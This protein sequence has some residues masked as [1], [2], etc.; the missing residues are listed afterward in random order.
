MVVAYR[1][2]DIIVPFHLGLRDVIQRRRQTDDSAEVVPIVPEPSF[3]DS[4][5]FPKTLPQE[6][7]CDPL[8]DGQELVD[9]GNGLLLPVAELA[10]C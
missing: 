9:L 1:A 8:G 3:L 7:L 2:H 5:G 6:D 10:L 4:F